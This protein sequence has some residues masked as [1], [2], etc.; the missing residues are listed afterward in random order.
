MFMWYRF[1]R[2]ETISNLILVM[3]QEKESPFH[4]NGC[5]KITSNVQKHVWN[6]PVHHKF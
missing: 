5:S 6:Y 3:L 1:Q 2:R 4:E